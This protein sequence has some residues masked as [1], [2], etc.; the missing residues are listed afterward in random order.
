MEK[1]INT[2]NRTENMN[3]T[4]MK[5]VMLSA[6]LSLI[7]FPCFC[8]GLIRVDVHEFKEAGDSLRVCYTA[9]IVVPT[10][11]TGQGLCITP[12]VEA[13]DSLLL[14]PH[15][16]ILGNNKG[17]VIARYR[18]NAG[19]DGK[20]FNGNTFNSSGFNSS[21]YINDKDAEHVYTVSVPYRLWMDSAALSIRQETAGYRAHKLVTCYRF[22]GKV[23]L[24]AKEAY[25]P[26]IQIAFIV[27]EKEEK[28]R[29]CQ[30]QAF[31]DFQ[32]GRSVIIPTFRRNP[33]ELAKIDRAVSD[34]VNNPDASL[35]GLYIEGY[36]SPE[37]LYATN[38]RLSRE[39][40]AALKDYL[41][42]KFSLAEET[43]K[44]NS[45]AENWDGLVEMV[46]AGGMPQKDRILEIIATVNVFD[47]REAALMKLDRG[48]PYRQ[49]LREIFP[50]LRKVEYRIDYTVRD[51]CPQEVQS[52]SLIWPED[53]SELEFYRLALASKNKEQGTGAD[54]DKAYSHIL[55]EV[56]P[57]YFPDSASAMNNAAAILLENGELPTAKR[58]LE[59]AGASP[60]A[61]NNRG[62]ASLLEGDLDKAEGYLD[63][64]R[65]A[66]SPQA[67]HNLEEMR[68]KR[69]DN[70]KME[71]YQDRR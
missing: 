22:P 7:V 66:G 24:E 41:K 49:M 4:S 70:K 27:P 2:N 20:S 6:L 43:F 57:K 47:G 15:V 1:K 11:A 36:A 35:L 46:R 23:E 65:E 59:R 19:A 67:V 9:K 21:S 10:V 58:Y 56:I 44:I 3:T 69:E 68:L 42:D 26:E 8:Q 39:R 12:V 63:K 60:Q 29:K 55:L 64:A 52:I 62:V 50:G 5:G 33:A 45:V 16:T 38:E 18:N 51:Y 61:L 25:R 30:K 37:G 34:V 53:L 54:K 14:L 28:R 71:R 13:G 48:V 40:A 31:L 32:A 17:K